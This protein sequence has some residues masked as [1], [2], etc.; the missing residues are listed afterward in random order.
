MATV[1]RAGGGGALAVA[2]ASLAVFSWYVIGFS[3]GGVLTRY[4]NLAIFTF[5]A[6]YWVMA[7]LASTS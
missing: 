2:E 5:S 4:S 6:A 3:Q 1:A 7:L